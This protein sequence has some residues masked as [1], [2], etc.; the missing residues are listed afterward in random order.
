[1]NQREQRTIKEVAAHAGVSIGTVSNVISGSA[2]VSE[3]LRQRVLSAVEHLQ[4]RPSQIA[5]SLKTNSSRLL[6]IVVSDIANPFFPLVV[7]G[8]EEA[9]IEAGYVLITC[10]SDG[11]P[12]REKQMLSMLT[13]H[14]VDGIL[15]VLARKGELAHIKAVQATGTPVVFLD[16]VPELAHCDSVS[17]DNAAGARA[18]TAHLLEMGHKYVGVIAGEE[19]IPV[20]SERLQGYRDALAAARVP[21][22]SS[23]VATGE[24]SKESAYEAT[25]RLLRGRCRPSAIFALNNVMTVGALQ[26]IQACGLRYGTDIAVASF[27]DLPY[28]EAM[29]PPITAVAQPSWEIGYEAAR[30]LIRRIKGTGEGPERVVLHTELRVRDS[31]NFRV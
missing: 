23:L 11:K 2:P 10:N 20:S 3:A 28:F 22:R 13:E 9:A 7:R 8:A 16:R 19:S 29:L 12:E 15:T 24:F 4:F 27:D 17:V 26:A 18:C 31:T 5:R 30:L 6:G 14:R 21:F 25:L 1:M